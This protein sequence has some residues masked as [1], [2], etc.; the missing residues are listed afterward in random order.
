MEDV[1]K[2]L[3]K[4]IENPP[5]S[6]RVIPVIGDNLRTSF[7]CISLDYLVTCLYTVSYYTFQ[8][9]VFHTKALVL[10][11]NVLQIKLTM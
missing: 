9:S 1:Y 4:I 3:C 8:Y 5:E 11:S 2:L 7:N 10:P 6:K